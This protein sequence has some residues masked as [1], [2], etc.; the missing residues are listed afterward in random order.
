MLYMFSDNDVSA[1]SFTV[2]E[3]MGTSVP[4][5]LTTVIATDVDGDTVAYSLTS[6]PPSVSLTSCRRYRY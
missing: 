5:L 2:A 6:T 3:G 1:L 4:R